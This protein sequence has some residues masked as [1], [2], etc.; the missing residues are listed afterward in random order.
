MLNIKLMYD[1]QVGLSRRKK[2]VV[3]PEYPA[4]TSGGDV[5][6]DVNISSV[7]DRRIKLRIIM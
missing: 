5:E 6:I 1:L 4:P 2:Y 7:E 3:K